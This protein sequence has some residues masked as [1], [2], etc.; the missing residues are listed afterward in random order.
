[1]NEC[2]AHCNRRHA[3]LTDKEL[4]RLHTHFTSI[5]KRRLQSFARWRQSSAREDSVAKDIVKE[6]DIEKSKVQ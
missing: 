5:S 2:P 1:M 4:N 3:F 6:D